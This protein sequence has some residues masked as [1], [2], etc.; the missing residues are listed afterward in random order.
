MRTLP[1]IALATLLALALSCGGGSKDELEFGT[2]LDSTGMGLAGEGTTFTVGSGGTTLYF[3]LESTADFD[4]RFVRLYF[5]SVEYKDFSA[6]AAKNTHV[7]LSGFHVSNPGTF[8]VKG[9]LVKD[10]LGIGEETLVATKS[11][12]LQ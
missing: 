2:G 12:T 8:E 11:L 9:Y 4:G 6:C 7:C 1:S 10:N 5:S 3:R